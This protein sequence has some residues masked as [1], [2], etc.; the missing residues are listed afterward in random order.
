MHENEN[1]EHKRSKLMTLVQERDVL[2]KKWLDEAKNDI[3]EALQTDVDV[4]TKTSKSDLVTN[5]DREIEKKFVDAIKENFPEDQ[6]VSEEGYGDDPEEINM[7]EETVWFLDPI[8]GTL[9]FVMQEEKFAVMLAVYDKGIGMQ[10]YIYDI[11]QDR[12]YWAI[13]GGGVYCN[14]QLLPKMEDKAL[15]DG[16]FAPNSMYLSDQQVDLNLEITKRSMGA[17]VIGSAGIEATEVAKGSTVAYVSYGLKSWDIAPGLI[18]VEE[19]GGVVTQFDGDPIDLL[20]PEPT[21]MGTPTAH[22]TIKEFASG[23][24]K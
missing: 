11:I 22:R 2:I 10:S 12:L 9:N 24:Q 13:K 15:E 20:N 23:F 5:M 4:E 7:G 14:D 3:F 16:L 1:Y 18:M 21:I 6:I 8:D 17:R 19:N